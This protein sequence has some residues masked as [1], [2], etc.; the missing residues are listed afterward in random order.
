MRRR[1]RRLLRKWSFPIFGWLSAF[2]YLIVAGGIPLTLPSPATKDPSAAFP[3]MN[4]PCGC[5]N[6]HQCWSSC[7]CHS[8]A[9]RLAWARDHG[10]AP[11]R[12]LIALVN[13]G[14]AMYRVATSAPHLEAKTCCSAKRTCSESDGDEC[15]V[16]HKAPTR[17]PAANDT[18]LGLSAL[19]CHGFGTNWLAAVVALPPVATDCGYQPV[20]TDGVSLLTVQFSSP[21][22]SPPVPPPRA[23]IL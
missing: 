11:P 6:A 2:I 5:R 16:S 15:Q 12:E 22:L 7:C 23:P 19:V 1:V 18:I 21:A 14:P 9:E 10:V 13:A 4:S 3:C 8:P 17:R 20:P